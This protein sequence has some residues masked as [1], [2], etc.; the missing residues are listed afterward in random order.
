MFPNYL[1][2]DEEMLNETTQSQIKS[3]YYSDNYLNMEPGNLH[4]PP[5]S[6]KMETKVMK[7][8][9]SCLEKAQ[10]F[11]ISSFEQIGLHDPFPSEPKDMEDFVYPQAVDDLAYP[12]D[13]Y[14]KGQSPHVL[15]FP[16]KR[17][18]FKIMRACIGVTSSKDL[19]FNRLEKY[20]KVCN[21]S[22]KD[23]RK[24]FKD[25]KSSGK[26]KNQTKKQKTLPNKNKS[27]EKQKEK[28]DLDLIDKEAMGTAVEKQKTI[29][30]NDFEK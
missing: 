11:H 30:K 4:L 23:K 2:C 20:T 14:K 8:F 7:K 5:D 18:M 3:V 19:W 10:P 26:G 15:Y 22:I 21:H 13:A 27:K 16:S 9:E 24:T 28:D 25:S 1:N 6:A 12:K 17:L 29:V